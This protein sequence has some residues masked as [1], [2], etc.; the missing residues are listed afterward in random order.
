MSK[1][2]VCTVGLVPVP[3]PVTVSCHLF[4]DHS[5]GSVSLVKCCFESVFLLF[6]ICTSPPLVFS[7]VYFLFIIHGYMSYLTS[8]IDSVFVLSP[9]SL[10]PSVFVPCYL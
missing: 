8:G 2:L 7:L 10:L 6:I 5:S 1:L 9:T 3:V 4:P